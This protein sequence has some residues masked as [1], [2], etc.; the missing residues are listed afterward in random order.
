MHIKDFDSQSELIV[1]F[2]MKNHD[3]NREEAMKAWYNSKT[4]AE[5]NKRELFY[6]SA[7]RAYSELLM[8]WDNNDEWMRN[9][10][11]M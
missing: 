10:F 4:Y 6:I 2:I 5:I 11:D 9:P 8:E 3:M 1:G 7:T